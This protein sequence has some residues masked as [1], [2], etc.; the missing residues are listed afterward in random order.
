MFVSKPLYFTRSSPG[1]FLNQK[2]LDA[3][4][5]YILYEAE[6][7]GM[8]WKIIP[9]T[10]IIELTYNNKIQYFRNKTPNTNSSVAAA[11]CREKYMCKSMLKQAGLSTSAGFIITK[12]DADDYI[13]HVWQALQKPL[14]LKPAQGTEGVGV[15][16]GLINF[17]ECLDKINDYFKSPV[18]EGGLILEEMFTGNEYRILATREKIMAVMERVPAY[19][20]GDG[21]H[22]IEE[23]IKIENTNP[24]RNISQTLYPHI[25]LDSSSEELLKKENLVLA[26]VPS[27]KQHVTLKKVSNLM[28]GGI[29]IDRT[30]EIHETVR[31]VCLKTIQA[32]PGLTWAG[33]DFMTKD[34]Y[35]PQSKE[36]YIIIE[37][38]SAPGFIIHDIP[39][40]GSPRGVA[41]ELI[42]M[43]FP[44]LRQSR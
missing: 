20:I 23:L 34:I 6:Q 30:D 40:Q 31:E 33:I 16:V 29:G 37:I 26:S 41:K 1:G 27:K 28:A 19:I 32:I 22:S 25:F 17:S 9:D 2:E 7:L 4:T 24:L 11:I 36:S 39:M 18:Y 3:S 15:E 5:Q 13:E 10:E 35:S 12:D 8:E 38:N 43:M 44:E 14:V 21:K 42:S